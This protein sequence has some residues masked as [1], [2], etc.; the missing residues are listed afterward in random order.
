MSSNLRFLSLKFTKLPR[1]GFFVLFIK[2]AELVLV[3]IAR[4]LSAAPP[5]LSVK[6]ALSSPY[7]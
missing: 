4:F 5:E 7:H 1:K 6:N 2:A 3:V